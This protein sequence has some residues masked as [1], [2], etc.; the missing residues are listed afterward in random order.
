VDEGVVNPLTV[1][2]ITAPADIED[3]I[4]TEMTEPAALQE[5]E[6]WEISPL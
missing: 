6:L 1:T 2:W 5:R 3:P 4:V